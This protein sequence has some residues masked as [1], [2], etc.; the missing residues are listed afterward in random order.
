[1]MNIGIDFDNT[2]AR[3]DSLFP[4]IAK[5]EGF[6]SSN[7]NGSGKT[8]LRDHLQGQVKGEK[9]W[10]K[11]QGLIYGKYMH[12]AEVMAGI[13]NF[14]LSCKVQNHRVFIVSHKTEYGHYDPEK[15]PL[16]RMALQW[17]ESN[18]FFDPEYFGL[19][20]D[21]VFFANTREEKVKKIRLLQCDWFIDDLPE[22]FKERLFPSKTKKILF[23]THDSEIVPSLIVLNSWR[24]ISKQ[25]LGQITG[26]DITMWSR[27]LLNEN[28]KHIEK[29]PGRGNSR[30]YKIIAADKKCY[31]LKYYPE[32]ISDKRPRL[33]TEF[34]AL[35]FLHQHNITNVPKAVEKNDNLNLG[36]YEWINGNNLGKPTIGD[37]EQAI[38]F[39]NKLYALSNTIDEHQIQIASEACLSGIELLN[40][41]EKRLLRLRQISKHF[42]ELS[43]FLDCDFTP[44]WSEVRD[45][46][47]SLWPSESRENNLSKK[48]QTLS[49]S[50]FGFHNCLK[51][52]DGSISFIDFDYFGW[53]DPVKFTADFIWHPAMTL[54]DKMREKWQEAMLN[55]FKDDLNFKFRLNAAIPLYGLRWALIVL[56]EFLPG[57]T[58]RRKS[59]SE[60]ASYDPLKSQTIQLDKAKQICN[61]VRALDVQAAFA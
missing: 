1:M 47:I 38:N 17:M 57:F 14:F 16:R 23:G 6:I 52:D 13:A 29:I 30:V 49:P 15:I 41:I 3:Y 59:A 26:E 8:A 28:I 35:C 46:N 45:K 32:Q 33:K 21:D 19:N 54:N 60:S 55:L 31:A 4:R 9:N 53:D 58:D 7:W 10:M 37:I 36:L 12:D 39:A 25:I 20:K 50:D 43:M 56:N 48:K 22:V 44:I 2:I 51:I 27:G 5:A 42:Q 61:K 24:D 40:Q 11:L 34:S 18:H